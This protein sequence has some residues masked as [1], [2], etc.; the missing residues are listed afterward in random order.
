MLRSLTLLV[1][2]SVLT[3]CGVIAA[4]VPPI[5]V[6]DVLGVEG[7]TFS[8]TF[9]GTSGLSSQALSAAQT[10]ITRTFEDTDLDLRGFSLSGLNAAIGIDTSVRVQAPS[11]GMPFP[12]SFM[13][14]HVA[15][16]ATVSDVVNGEASMSMRDESQLVFELD[17]STCDLNGCTYRYAS[18]ASLDDLLSLHVSSGERATLAAFVTI[19]RL[20]GTLSLNTGTFTGGVAVES[21]A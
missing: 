5:E 8:T 13:L 12:E 1:L 11:P 10:T 9:V 18:E 3:G 2:I 4:L 20:Q 6:G 7:Q 15:A 19:I 21:L 16:D 17:A 14:T